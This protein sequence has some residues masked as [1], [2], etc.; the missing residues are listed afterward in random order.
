MSVRIREATPADASRIAAV[1]E[2]AWYE[3][4]APII[5]EEIVAEFLAKYYDTDSLREVIDRD[6][7]ITT[8]AEADEEV[9]GFV[10][11]GPDDDGPSLLH[12]NRIYIR[13]E[14]WGEGIGGRLVASFEQDARALESDRISL[15]VMAENERA[16][17]FYE[18]A[19]FDRQEKIYDEMV[20]TESYI[21]HKKL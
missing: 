19:G 14:R 17:R 20:E 15:R 2:K 18:S 11:G 3:A 5:G 13:P 6:G 16:V 7:W 4:H 10:S 9:V 8:V 12:L 21:Y 1:A